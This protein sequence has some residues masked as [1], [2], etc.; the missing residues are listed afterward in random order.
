M[1]KPKT[2][3]KVRMICAVC[4]RPLFKAAA[5]Q[6]GLPVGPVCAVAAGLLSPKTPRAEGA[7]RD[8]LTIDLFA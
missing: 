2:Y 4:H 7:T 1:K 5:L 3:P 8:T 6:R